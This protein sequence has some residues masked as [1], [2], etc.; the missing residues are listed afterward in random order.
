MTKKKLGKKRT[1]AT[2]TAEFKRDAIAMVNKE[3]LPIAR[4]AR[5]LGIHQNTLRA[6]LAQAAI[7]AQG[8]GGDKLTTEEKA[9][10]RRLRREV[11]VLKEER[12][13]LKK[14]AAWFAAESL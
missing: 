10:L 13:I 12:A 14:A 11:K 8:G 5:D 6:W 1:R 7:D 9:E 3:R 4:A 2:Y